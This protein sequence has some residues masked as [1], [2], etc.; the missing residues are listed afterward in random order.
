MNEKLP[1][2]ASGFA[3]GLMKLISDPNVSS[4]KLETL[5]K[6]QAQALEFRAREDFHIAYAQ[7]SAELPQVEREGRVELIKDNRRL[8]GY[9]YARWEDMDRAIR[10]LLSKHGFA[11]SFGSFFG[12]DQRL[13]VRGKLLHSGGHFEEAEFPVMSDK[14]PGRNEL[15]AMGSGVSYA[16][17][18]VAEMLLNIVRKGQDDDGIA[19]LG[20]K[21]SQNQ[22]DTLE[23]L[24]SASKSTPDKFLSIMVTGVEQLSDVPERDYPRL[25]NALNLQITRNA[26]KK[27][28]Q[29]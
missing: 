8:G 20:R 15:Q 29:K 28:E 2:T 4:D 18:Y 6:L 13:M 25:V 11:F 7:L 16:K 5:L 19:A 12:P 9:R 24:I 26:A 1:A 27:K 3:D 23:K 17:R 10:P 14:G 22:I 21:I